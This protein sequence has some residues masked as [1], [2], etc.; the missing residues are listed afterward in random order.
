MIWPLCTWKP[1]KWYRKLK[2][3][4]FYYFNAYKAHTKLIKPQHLRPYVQGS[5]R[6]QPDQPDQRAPALPSDSQLCNALRHS[7]HPHDPCLLWPKK[8]VVAF[9]EMWP[10]GSDLFLMFLH[11]WKRWMHI[12]NHLRIQFGGCGA[13]L[14]GIPDTAMI[15]KNMVSIW[16]ITTIAWG[17]I[18]I[19]VLPTGGVRVSW[20]NGPWG[21]N[22]FNW[23]VLCS[24]W[25]LEV[26][27][28]C[29]AFQTWEPCRVNF[30]S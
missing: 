11:C 26:K 22:L 15:L 2:R 10:I 8:P 4:I 28:N 30:S 5:N 3:H 12:Y 1:G 7:G 6:I 14:H 23:A 25:G 24:I 18:A 17:S 19:H 21:C 27:F 29:L 9:Q 16:S 13:K 20:S